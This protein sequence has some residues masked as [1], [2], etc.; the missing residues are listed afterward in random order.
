MKLEHENEF[1][2]LLKYVDF[3]A[4][5]VWRIDPASEVHPSNVIEESVKK[6]GKSKALLIGLRQAANDTVEESRRWNS[7]IRT[8]VD[9]KFRAA[10][11]V[12]VS[13]ITRRYASSYK[14]IVSRGFIK[15]ET[16]Y[17]VINAIL[18]DQSN[19][20][21]D[22]ERASLQRLTDAYEGA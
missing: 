17:Y 14:R 7:E 5:A 9:E 11:V 4:T 21:S 6:F 16:E 8:N 10:G 18:I 1:N 20:I 19:S 3:F 22:V 13:E 2:E 12:T 15:N